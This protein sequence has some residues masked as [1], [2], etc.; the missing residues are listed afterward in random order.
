MLVRS[1]AYHLYIRLILLIGLSVSVQT[2]RAMT[3]DNRNDPFPIFKT[4]DAQTFL[5]IR[6]TSILKGYAVDNKRQERISIC[7]SPFAQR[8]VIG[9][10]R[11]KKDINLGN[12]DGPWGMVGLLMGPIPEGYSL[13][14]ALQV[15][16]QQLF[17]DQPA[18][19]PIEDPYAVDP[20]E[21]CGFF[22]IPANYRKYGM[23]F[24]FEAQLIGDVGFS[25]DVGLADISLTPCSITNLTLTAPNYEVCDPFQCD[26]FNP[27][28]TRQNINEYLMGPYQE[29]MRE[30]CYDISDF[31]KF[32]VEDIR[33]FIY[34][35]HLY[36]MNAYLDEWANF[37]LMPFFKFGGTVSPNKLY[38]PNETF[39]LSFGSQ[40]HDSVGF[41]A[42]INV[43]FEDTVELG[44]ETG[45]THFFGRQFDNYHV[46]T[47]IYQ[48]G[49]YPFTTC[50]NINPGANYHFTAKMNVYHF[51]GNLSF[52]FQYVLVIHTDD[53]IKLNQPNPGHAF[54]PELLEKLSPFRVQV[55]NIA[56]NY[57]ITPQISLGFLWQAPLSQYNAF[58]S[59][60]VM[61]GFNAMF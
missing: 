59:T 32:S 15:A 36:P 60:T 11:C 2:I 5:L 25:L 45:I 12:M 30:I 3:A 4:L 43:D 20:N 51:M 22:T 27:N 33:A 16:R 13:P 9:K 1:T 47:S 49:V 21:T 35:R 57:D 56:F 19:S 8:A 40:N 52:L 37:L 42:G 31:N 24:N 44:G 10:D 41:T 29:I 28:L 6:E 14:P 50:V 18:G 46:P 38:N 53:D 55:A 23:R 61:V 34:W 58:R 7:L 48:K 54:K 26:C 39:A 17:P